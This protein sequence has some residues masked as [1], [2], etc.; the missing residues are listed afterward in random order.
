MTAEEINARYKKD[1]DKLIK[2]Y[3]GSIKDSEEMP[4]DLKA[5]KTDDHYPEK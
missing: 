1:Q 4:L 5:L 3:G 2:H